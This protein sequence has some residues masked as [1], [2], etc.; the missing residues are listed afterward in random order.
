MF[1]GEQ[2]VCAPVIASTSGVRVNNQEAAAYAGLDDLGVINYVEGI[3]YDTPLNNRN[4]AVGTAALLERN[5]GCQILKTPCRHH[6]WDLFGKNIK[7]VV[8]G[9]P[10]SGP[11]DPVFHKYN[12]AYPELV[13]HIDY[14]NLTIFNIAAW[15]GTFVEQMVL[16]V[17]A[18]ARHAY[19]TEV[20]PQGDYHDL[21]H[22]LIKF[23]GADPPDFRFRFK[24]PKRVSNARFM[25][26]ADYYITMELL[27]RQLNI[28]TP[29]EKTEVTEM[30][31]ISALFYG[32]GFLKSSVGSR[33]S[34][35]DLSSI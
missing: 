24:K 2:F 25:Q 33:A 11:G 7:Q 19:N 20:F 1:E 12:K 8:S 16:D 18:W 14:N 28:L 9:R 17:R 31:F 29:D 34:F 21:L 27:S 35:N 3:H 5:R 22:L 13:D 32:P 26:P 23:I 6:I 10:S 15:R 4:V 30:A